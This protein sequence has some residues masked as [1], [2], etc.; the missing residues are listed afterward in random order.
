MRG[1][2]EEATDQV[3]GDRDV[4]ESGRCECDGGA[5]PYGKCSASV[6]VGD[7]GDIQAGGWGC[8]RERSER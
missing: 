2:R 5:E 3:L 1:A 8:A 4:C 6:T 7:E